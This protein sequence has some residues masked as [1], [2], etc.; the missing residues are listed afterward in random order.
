MEATFT[1]ELVSFVIDETIHELTPQIE[2]LINAGSREETPL[3]TS[4]GEFT[5]LGYTEQHNGYPI[6]LGNNRM[7]IVRPDR[8][9]GRYSISDS[10]A[11]T[12]HRLQQY[13]EELEPN[14]GDEKVTIDYEDLSNLISLAT[15]VI[16]GAKPGYLTRVEDSARSQ[17]LAKIKEAPN[18]FGLTKE[19]I[20]EVKRIRNLLDK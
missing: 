9:L 13:L 3:K 1:S 12:P 5:Y 18:R 7:F 11:N 16:P 6:F 4:I 2:A 8:D 14:V 15:A 17:L 19:A 10:M 20:S